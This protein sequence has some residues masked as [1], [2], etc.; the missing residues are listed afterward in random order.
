MDEQK[1][2]S[3]LIAGGAICIVAAIVGGG[4]SVHVVS[5][6]AMSRA[7]QIVL[8]NFGLVLAVIGF[9][10]LRETPDTQV[11][12]PAQDAPASEDSGAAQSGDAPK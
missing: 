3:L 7:R 5:I 8:A 1:L 4:L 11:E 9:L 12:V 10:N 6:P 2:F